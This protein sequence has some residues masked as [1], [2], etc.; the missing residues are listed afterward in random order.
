MYAVV[1]TGGKQYKV[2]A[3]EKI[4]VEQ[5]PAD[6]GAAV[7][8]DQVLL[9]QSASGTDVGAP[10]VAGASVKATV[11]SHGRADKVKIFKMR[12]RK[13]YR[14]QQGHRQN[15]TELFIAAILGAGGAVIAEAS[16]AAASVAASA[17]PKATRGKK[18]MGKTKD[19]T[20]DLEIVEGIGPKIAG[21]LRAE[22]VTTFAKLAATS[23]D[24]VRAILSKA[25][26]NLASHDPAS[27][28]L[29]AKMADEGKWDEL[30][31]WQ[32]EHVAGKL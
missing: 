11:V 25:G 27:W 2:A 16:G 17:A 26:G 8:L 7:V 29:Q 30:K 23:A 6:V 28:G 31:K 10:L 22:G 3:G 19:G 4:Q 14:K 32:D 5:I 18:V 15:Y 9:V 21:V 20:D 24:D 12:R 13:H 1:K